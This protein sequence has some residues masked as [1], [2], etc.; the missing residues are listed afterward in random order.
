MNGADAAAAE[1]GRH[2]MA[3][4]LEAGELDE[5]LGRLYAAPPALAAGDGSGSEG[6]RPGWLPTSERFLDPTTDRLM[7]VW[8]DPETS[9]R[10]YV[11]EPQ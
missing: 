7:R 4:H 3:G 9:T 8:L 10:N 6:A 1:L 5:R 2:Y 11:P